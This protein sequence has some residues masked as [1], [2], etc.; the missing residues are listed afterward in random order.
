MENQSGHSRQLGRSVSQPEPRPSPSV[1]HSRRFD[2]SWVEL[3]SQPSSS[4]L[5]SVDNEIVTTGLQVGS[6]FQQRRRRL[7]PSGRSLPPQQ[8]AIHVAGASSQDEEDEES[9]SDEDR[10]MTSSA[11]N[12]HSSEKDASDGSDDESDDGDNATTL[13]RNSDA[14]VFRPHPNAFSHPPAGLVQRS[15]STSSAEH[16]HPHS[17]F[18]RSSYPHRQAR[19]HRGAPNFMSPSVREDNDA[20]LRASLTT[21]LS[22]AAAARGLPKNKEE[23][24]AQRTT[25]TGVAP[26]NQPV[27]L[28]FM[29]ESELVG[30]DK[31]AEAGPSAVRRRR[32]SSGA[33]SPKSK[34]SESAG[35]GP[36]PAK[37]KRT[38]VAAV[39]SEYA[40]ISPTLLSWVVSAGVVVL[41]SVVG[42]GAGYV[43]GREVG[44]EEAR[45][46]LAASVGGV[47]DTTS[48][49]GDVIRSSVGLRKLRWSAVGRSI[50]A[51]A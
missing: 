9:D 1:Y 29:P 7:H 39:D 34:R 27:E 16:P 11:E 20:A 45:E 25:R 35:R 36:R 22:C 44:R 18:R 49:G 31:Q 23:T 13:G 6:P 46:V 50:V 30:E 28:R 38:A 14:P 43:I 48:A 3:S 19:A 4:S 26:S 32:P 24:D 12:I 40:L 42:F 10:V 41:V 21:L 15:Y 17:S 8:T 37:K 5:S 33:V 2:E 51:Q 47:N